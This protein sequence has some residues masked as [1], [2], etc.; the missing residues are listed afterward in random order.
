MDG[1]TTMALGMMKRVVVE[2]QLR[3]GVAVP[4]GDSQGVYHAPTKVRTCLPT[5]IESTYMVSTARAA[6]RQDG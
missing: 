2:A 3:G 1:S 6:C 4:G 5:G